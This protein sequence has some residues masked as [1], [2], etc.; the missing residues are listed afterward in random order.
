MAYFGILNAQWLKCNVIAPA[1]GSVPVGSI[2]NTFDRLEVLVPEGTTLE[3]Y[4]DITVTEDPPFEYDRFCW[5]GP[6]GSISVEGSDPGTY[7]WSAP[8][9]P[10]NMLFPHYY[11]EVTL[12]ASDEDMTCADPITKLL[13]A[14][15]Y[16]V[17]YFCP[18]VPTGGEFECSACPAG[19]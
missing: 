18:G 8:P 15:I 6:A 11:A 14:E 12:W 1:G 19:L 9:M 10:Y 3:F 2:N 13:T 17:T 4:P 7:R 5:R 16:V